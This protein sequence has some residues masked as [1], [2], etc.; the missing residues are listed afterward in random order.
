[1]KEEIIEYLKEKQ[2]ASVNELAA[3]LEKE[4]SKDFSALVKTISQLERKHQ[5]RF[6]DEGRI[7]LY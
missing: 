7:E 6:D 4:S 2:Q 5:L 3:A 1:M